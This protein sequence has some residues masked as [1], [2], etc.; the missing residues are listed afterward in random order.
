MSRALPGA[1]AFS[2]RPD[3]DLLNHGSFGAVPR[4]V[5]AAQQ[6]LRREMEADPLGFMARVPRRLREAATRVGRFVGAR[7]RDLVF[8]DNAT[9]GVATVL[10]SLDW[11]RGDR[12][13]TTSHVYGAVREAL[14][15][16]ARRHG[17]VV[18]EVVVPFPCAGPEAV[19][20]AVVP[21]LR[22]AR[23]AVLDAITSPTGLVLPWETLVDACRQAGV[24][25]LVDGAHAPG[26]VALDLDRVGPDWF[27]GN[28]H[29]WAFGPKGTAILYARPDR[30]AQTEPL[31]ASHEVRA[32]WPVA[33]D[34]TGT[35]DVTG[36]LAS[37]A[38]LDWIDQHGADAIR[39]HNDA[40]A[41]WAGAFLADAWGVALPAPGSMRAA[42]VAVPAP[43]GLDAVH[44]PAL[45]DGLRALGTEVP[46]IPFAGRTW[47]RVSGQLFVDRQAVARLATRAEAVSAR[48]RGR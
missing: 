31:V 48:L 7:G 40:L 37:S 26:Q 8:V 36:W 5:Q 41:A 4:V 9:T 33:H 35:R 2:L 18:D 46:C 12:I 1:E 39:A 3:L 22:G 6:R 29:K 21:R 44:A 25:V 45:H 42:M 15:R 16:V 28:L 14:H 38:A 13:V 24:P 32:G 11:R 20:E 23:L 27:T 17:A 43:G 19:L 10:A 47:V 34:W 30:Q